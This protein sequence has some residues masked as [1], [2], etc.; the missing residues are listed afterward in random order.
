MIIFS[1]C[2]IL[3]KMRLAKLLEITIIFTFLIIASNHPLNA[4][5]FEKSEQSISTF[6]DTAAELSNQWNKQS[7]QSAVEIYK[8][9]ASKWETVNRFDNTS[10]CIQESARLQLIL[11]E[12]QSAIKSL[13]NSQKLAK[14]HNQIIESAKTQSYLSLAFL[15][16]GE[17]RNSSKYLELALISSKNSNDN[18]TKALAY[19][20]GGEY[21]YWQNENKKSLDFYLQANQLWKELGEPFHQ[22]ETLIS[23]AYIYMA[24]GQPTKGLQFAEDAEKLFNETG[25]QRGISLSQ[26]AVGHLL[27]ALNKKQKALEYYFKAS[28]NFPDDLDLLDKGAL[29]NG[30]GAIYESY[31]QLETSLSY[32]LK[33]VE[34]FERDKFL[35]GQLGTMHSIIGLYYRLDNTSK[36]E[37]YIDKARRL[38]RIV[39][40]KYQISLVYKEIAD[41][42][43]AKKM[44]AKA[45]NYYCKSLNET[46]SIGYKTNSILINNKLGRIFLRNNQLNLARKHF[47][48]SLLTSKDIRN[49]FAQ[50]ETFFYLAQL[51]NSL[52]NEESFD[53][54]KSSINLT[55]TLYADVANSSLKRTYFSNVYERYELYIN[56]LMQKHKQSPNEDF[57]IQALQASERS[58][59]RSLLET[60]RLSEANFTKDANP[61]AVQKEKELLTLLNLKASKLTELLSGGGEKAEIDKVDEERRMLDNELETVKSDLK[62]NSPVYTAIKNPPPFDV[63]E[64]QQNNLDDK[65]VCLE[66]AFGEKES[67]LWLIGKTEVSSYVLP[68]REVLENRIDKIRQAFENR[69]IMQGEDGDIYQ[70]RIADLESVSN[71]ESKL[72][73]DELLGQVVDKIAD[74]RLIIVPDGKLALLP[75]S[76]LPFPNSTEYLIIKNE[77]VYEP[78]ASLLNILP[79][80]QTRKQL[81]NKDLLVFADPVFNNSDNRLTAKI[82]TESI[83]PS[84]L[85]LNLRDFRLTDANGK[86]PRLFATQTEA[87]SIAETV[88]KSHVEILSGFAANRERVV[89]SDI[90]DYQILHF[91]T[92]GLI[93]VN[94]PE[95]SSIVLSQFDE[96]G[97]KTEGFLRLQDIYSLDLATDLVVLSACRS[98]IGKEIK[99]EGLM[100]LNNAFLQAGAKSVVSSAW[101]VDDNAT[102]EFMKRFYAN[103]TNKRLTTSAALQQ[104]QIEM[105]NFTQFKSPFYWAAFTVQGEFRQPIS[106]SR[107]YFYSV[108]IGVFVLIGIGLLWKLRWKRDC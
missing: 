25:N 6:E 16:I 43:F 89:H 77:L 15:K 81:P 34:A 93:D 108:L 50:S 45:L 5:T 26:I 22:A 80:I 85:G 78:S 65:T 94:R 97:H 61:Q 29:L 69:Q 87:D 18:F 59:S 49:Y 51:E 12:N 21:Y 95:V 10:R 66:F 14:D 48:L 17:E 105:V 30:F 70:K 4:Q 27:S 79:K 75:L 106:V 60:L 8:K 62:Q 76:A 13:L 41:N 42:Y 1:D 37:N 44:D 83:L 82:E 39:K 64:F 73:S 56:L 19:Y 103:L 40:D 23:T 92:H 58:R 24:L 33:A 101:K 98:G 52:Q 96:N 20:A 88:G 57:A 32:R 3:L 55:E 63:A 68:P 71:T 84:V 72:L 90:S 100:S 28:K 46:N 74:K 54:I 53:F 91:A 9:A 104:T 67:Y 31:Q 86:I 38:S 36:A 7:F 47:D 107:N 102:A 35:F 99:G 2:K 11:G